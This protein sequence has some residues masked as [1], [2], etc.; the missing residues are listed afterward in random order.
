[1]AIPVLSLEPTEV[2]AGDTIKW[3]KSLSN[4]PASTW[5]LS[6]DIR[7]SA[8]YD[9]AWAAE[10]TADGNDFLITVP[11]ATSAA[12]TAGDYWLYGFVT[13]GTDRANVYSGRL[14]IKPNQGTA[15]SV[16]DGRTH[17]RKTLAAIEAVLEGT[18]TREESQ[19]SVAFGGHSRSLALRPIEELLKMREY[20][21]REVYEEEQAELMEKGLGTGN[22][23]LIRFRRP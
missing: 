16:Y 4:Y 10:V 15:T 19:L 1:M 22:R 18:A 9:L 17:A 5:Q 8:N 23:H 12:W 3:R 11:A 20:Y 6:Y 14:K 13:D 2:F 21:R 7:G